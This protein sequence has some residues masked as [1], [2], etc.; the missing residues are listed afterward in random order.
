MNSPVPVFSDLLQR[1]EA[2]RNDLSYKRK[3]PSAP[4]V[5]DKKRLTKMEQKLWF[6]AGR[7]TAG[8]KDPEALKA[9]RAV[10]KIAKQ[11]EA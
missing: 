5:D 7:A 6:D 9:L 10:K 8:A 3:E 2:E 4:K 11:N 1:L